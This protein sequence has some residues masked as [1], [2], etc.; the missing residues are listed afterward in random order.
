MPFEPGP[1]SAGSAQ[2][3]LVKLDFSNACWLDGQGGATNDRAAC[4]MG[5]GAAQL[6]WS[7]AG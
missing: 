2:K 3:V 4:S 6:F 1:N 7:A 5:S